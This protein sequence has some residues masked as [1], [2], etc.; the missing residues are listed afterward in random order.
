M[1]D[2]ELVAA[3]LEAET[4]ARAEA[5]RRRLARPEDY[6]YDKTQ[7]GFWDLVTGQLFAAKAVD[8][9]IALDD[10]PTEVVPAR[11]GGTRVRRLKP[12]AEI[13]RI[14]SGLMVDG[15]TWAPGE[16]QLL[17]N[18]VVT[19][20]GPMRVE[21][22]L[23]YNSYVAPERV[24]PA[25]E[26]A[27]RPWIE[28]VRRLFPD[29]AEHNHFFDWAAHAVQHPGVKANHGV[30]ISGRQGIGKDTALLPL[31]CGVGVWN[32]AEIGPDDVEA[33]F[34][35]W[36]RSVLLVINEVRPHNEEHRASGFYNR[37]KPLL[38]APPEF[39]A[40]EM[41]HAHVTYVKNCCRVVLTTND[42][43]TMHIPPEDRRLFVMHSQLAREW[44]P[45][46]YFDRLWRWFRA[47]GLA[48]AIGWLA[49]RD[50]SAFAAEAPPPMTWGKEQIIASTAHTRTNPISEAF[51]EWVGEGDAPAVWFPFDLL[52]SAFDGAEALAGALR[53]KSLHYR[54]ADLGYRVM[55]PPAGTTEWAWKA[56]GARVRSRVAFVRETVPREMA[57]ELVEAEGKKRAAAKAERTAGPRAC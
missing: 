25:T 43:L 47:G 3:A 38:A 29:P 53:A 22:A 26:E 4:A 14:E 51:A 9:S 5:F 41:K 34:N 57:V 20:R 46:G 33:R 54:V 45:E 42:H 37:I 48:A 2:E 40:M 13:A 12:T 16:P 23:T 32:S 56:G 39:L 30:V 36:I 50:V 1:T 8:A 19:D 7:D 11:G 10:W 28:H 6:R 27:A 21:G 24:A 18:V 17:E 35:A 52:E 31:R 44:A 55:Q 49:E 15:S